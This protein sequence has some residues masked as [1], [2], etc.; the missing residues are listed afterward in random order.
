MK[1]VSDIKKHCEP[2]VQVC[3]IGNK[4]DLDSESESKR[5]I[6]SEL[7]EVSKF[8]LYFALNIL[9]IENGL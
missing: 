7:G 8:L 9:I 4:I 1:W 5:K 3:L 2:S 6:S